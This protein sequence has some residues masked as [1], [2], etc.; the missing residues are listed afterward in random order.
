MKLRKVIPLALTALM[1]NAC[2]GPNALTGQDVGTVVGGAGGAMVGSLFGQGTGQ[3]LAT[4]A[5]AVVG[6]LAGDYAG[7]TYDNS[8]SSH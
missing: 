5:G 2:S 1:L 3:L 7:K 4:G 6:G 8:N